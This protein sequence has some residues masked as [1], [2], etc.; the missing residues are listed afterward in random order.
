MWSPTLVGV[1]ASS[2][3]A[4]EQTVEQ[5][6]ARSTQTLG[7]HWR[8]LRP[9]AQRFVAAFEDR[10]RP[11]HRDVIRF[12]VNDS[13]FERACSKYYYELSLKQLLFEPQ[14]MQP[15]AAARAWAVPAIETVG[16][17]AVWLQLDPGQ[18]DW[19]ADLAGLAHQNN[20]PRLDHYHYR[21][22]TKRYGNIRLIE[23]PKPRLKE[24]QRQILSRIL[25]KIPPHPA[26]HGFIKG[27]SIKTFVA[28][29]VGQ[30]VVLR[31][32]L[33]DFFPSIRARRIH[34]L[35]RTMG[36]PEAVADR[37][38]G[39]C[40]NVAP[41]GVWREP[42]LDVDPI[43]WRETR[44]LYSRPHL[45]QGA[46][47]SP[48]LA[49]LCAYRVD[50]RLTG[51]AESA[52]AV[53]TRYADDL[54]FSGEEAFDRGVARFSTH[55][56]AILHEE[57]FTVHH[58]KTRIMRQGVRQHLAG[59]VA[60]QRM[61]VMRPDFDLLKATLTNCVRLGPESQNREAHPLFRSHLD[62]RVAFVEMI[63]PAKGQRLRRIFERIRWL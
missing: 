38:G 49:N 10:T 60:N 15:V 24:L 9:L 29:H 20:R 11:G 33:R 13:G 52:G 31:M 23:A 18:L 56:A 26:A 46:P 34:A 63:N 62:G 12:L 44:A 4:G 2:F 28:P 7:K 57:G 8:W 27:R 19:F 1:L 16:D 41:G 22:L 48:A 45:P 61:N 54:A 5:I 59:V 39:I 25:D 40:T 43:R 42:P 53:Y 55:V 37:L 32:D 6:V 14:P 3:L 35:F 17:L 21:L 30:R 47:A 58:R 50:R 36:Y 51:L